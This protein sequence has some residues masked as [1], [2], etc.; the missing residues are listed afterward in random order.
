MSQLPTFQNAGRPLDRRTLLQAGAAAS[1]AVMLPAVLRGQDSP[2]P[3]KK[4]SIL[5]LGGTGFLGPAIVRAA[6]ARGHSLTLFNRG[7]T[8]T[9]LF[10]DVPRL[11]GDRDPDKAEGLKALAEGKWD[12]CFDDCG[13]YPRMVSASAELLKER[14]GHYVYVSSIS[15]YAKNEKEGADESEPVATMED[16]TVE[17]MG[18]GYANYGPL[19]A[20]CEQASEHAFPGRCAVIRPGYIVG[21][22]DPTDRY[23]YWPV[24]A[25]RG[26]E[27]LAPGAASDPIQV[28]DVRDLGEWMVRV[29]E[30]K[31]VGVFNACGPAKKLSMG[32]VIEA[33]RAAAAPES[34]SL[35]PVWV[36]HE[37]LAKQPGVDL[38]IWAPYAG[39]SRGFHTWSN[40][41]AVKAGLTFRSI[42]VTTKDTLTWHLSRPAERQAKLR[43]GL[44]AEKEAELLKLF[45]A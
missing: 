39:E 45:R 40:A 17:S 34:A 5:I 42:A 31:T 24:R 35:K 4:L 37:F 30:Q 18:E 33:C 7:K 27:M 16:P 10:P 28:I 25:T 8:R 20:L 44:S 21:P 43:A 36:D 15:A 9:E 2:P 3:G 23:T 32:E 19:K 11:V 41:R 38:P 12:V 26:G 29:A 13:Y 14:V 22:E 6:Q 1:A